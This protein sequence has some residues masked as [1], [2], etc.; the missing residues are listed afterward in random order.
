MS[1]NNPSKLFT[2]IR[3]GPFELSN[4]L[5]MAP[6]TR[7]RAGQ[8]NIPHALNATYYQQRASAGLIVT[9]ATQISPQ[10][11]GYPATPGIHSAEQVEGWKQ[12][13]SAV[14]E[15]GGKIFLQLWHVGRISHPSLQPNGEVP[16]APSA[17]APKGMA[18]TYEGAKPFVTPRALSL[19]EIPQIIN[20][21]KEAAKNAR[22][23]AFDGVE[24]HGANGY[25]I[26]QFI[27]SGSNKR[28]DAYGGSV[29]N[30]GRFA[31]EV[32]KAVSEVWESNRVGIRFSPSGTF[33]DMS[34]ENP[35]ET[36]GYLLNKL[37][38]ANLAYV[39]IVQGSPE[40]V[41]HG[42]RIVPP[43]FFR[44]KYSGRIITNGGYN[45]ERAEGV[46]QEG[47]AD[48]VAFGKLFLANPDLPERFKKGAVLNTPDES[49]FYGGTEKG[50]TDYPFL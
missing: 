39:H 26:D 40:D 25:L 47:L 7:N 35:E 22:K 34:D 41:K 29:E 17:I 30:R 4:R 10:G 19:E 3:V 49:T 44:E 24:I 48:L 45:R 38:D 50:Y 42:G 28:T 1:Q 5:V 43:S 8:K 18:I 9:E 23:A 20:E 46:L 15:K 11:V 37:N 6:L 31:L 21:Y 32:V 2:P 36:Y 33:N 14:H 12:V 13:T 16:V 27:R